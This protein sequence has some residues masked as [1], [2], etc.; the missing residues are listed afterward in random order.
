MFVI[1]CKGWDGISI[2]QSQNV[3]MES[4]RQDSFWTQGPAHGNHVELKEVRNLV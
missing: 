1:L 3:L 2:E 4:L